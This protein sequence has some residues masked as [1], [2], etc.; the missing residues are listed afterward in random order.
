MS[1]DYLLVSLYD[2]LYHLFIIFT[3]LST[4]SRLIK[5][6]YSSRKWKQGKSEE[7]LILLVHLSHHN[8]ITILPTGYMV[9]DLTVFH[10][11]VSVV[12]LFPLLS[13][14]GIVLEM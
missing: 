10:D 1:V 6:P 11:V 12:I 5:L 3:P 8:V 14:M 2:M 7:Q 13:P 9:G 4:Y